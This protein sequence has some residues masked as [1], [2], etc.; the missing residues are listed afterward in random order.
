MAFSN[1]GELTAAIARWLERSNLDTSIPDFIELAERRIF[2]Q[3]R[4]PANEVQLTVS[5][6]D[7]DIG[8]ALPGDYLEMRAVTW[9]GTALQRISDRDGRREEVGSTPRYF[10]RIGTRVYLYPAPAAAGELRLSYWEDQ[11]GLTDDADTSNVLLVA[12]DLYLFGALMEAEPFLMNDSRLPLWERKYAQAVEQLQEM[13]DSAEI[14][15][16]TMTTRSAY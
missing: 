7:P 2:R 10:A 4:C 12:P 8:Y 9:N 5:D 13:A 11:S 1:Y 16:G 15:G 14:S 6:Y 3:L